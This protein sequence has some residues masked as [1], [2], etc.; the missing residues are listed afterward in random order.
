MTDKTNSKKR[1]KAW[2]SE[3]IGKI[4]GMIEHLYPGIENEMRE[5]YIQKNQNAMKLIKSG[6][7]FRLA[8]HSWFLL[9]FEFPSGTTAIEMADSF[10]MKYFNEKEKKMIMNFLRY[11]ESLFEIINISEN[12][13]DYTLR[14]LSDNKEYAIR[15]ID[16]PAGF[17]EKEIVQAIIVKNLKKEYFF[18]GLVTSF[19]VFN[20]K[21]FVKEILEK[22]KIEEDI[23]RERAKDKIEWEILK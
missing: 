2:E 9:K 16:L 23:R 12:K 15:T 22:I 5:L 7:D 3:L 8:F 21:E 4:R 19:D 11:K 10:P 6:A 14:D 18:Y 13:K 20:R 1:K 17:K